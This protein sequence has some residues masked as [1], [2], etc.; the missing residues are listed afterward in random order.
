LSGGVAELP[1]A[2]Y[3][4]AEALAQKGHVVVGVKPFFE[5]F[6]ESEWRQDTANET[7]GF[8]YLVF[9]RQ[10]AITQALEVLLTASNGSNVDGVRF[11]FPESCHSC[12]R[13]C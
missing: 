12:C 1:E 8:S 4:F 13:I 7:L 5:L 6:S 2:Y 9:L 10:R 11:T 3:R